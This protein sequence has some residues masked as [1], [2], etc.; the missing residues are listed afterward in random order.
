MEGKIRAV[1]YAREKKIPYLGLCFGM[2]MAVIE[3]ARN[4]A[5]L[6]NANSVEADPKTEFPVIHIMKNQKE[7]LAKNQYGGL[8]G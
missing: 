4:V 2:Q 7:Y 6:S 1:Q 8:L 5:K 3:Y